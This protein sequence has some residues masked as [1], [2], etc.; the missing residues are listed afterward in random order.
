MLSEGKWRRSGEGERRKKG[1][2]GMKGERGNHSWL[3]IFERINE[4]KAGLSRDRMIVVNTK[5][6]GYAIKIIFLVLFSTPLTPIILPCPLP[7]DSPIY[8]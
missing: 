2:T 8:A 6:V 3:V 4:L 7:H 1:W 5:L